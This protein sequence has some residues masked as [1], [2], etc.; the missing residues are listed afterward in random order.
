MSS[1]TE[2]VIAAF[3]AN[4]GRFDSAGFGRDLLLMHTIGARTGVPKPAES[5]RPPLAW[6]A[7]T[8]SSVELLMATY[9]LRSPRPA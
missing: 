2:E 9:A 3:R 5:T 7:A 8:T 6:N 4:G 1:S